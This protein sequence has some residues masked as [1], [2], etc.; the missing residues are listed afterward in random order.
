M[1]YSTYFGG[2]SFVGAPDANVGGGIAVDPNNSPNMY[3][4]GTTNMLPGTSTVAGFP[5][6]NAQ[7]TCLN[8]ASVTTSPCSSTMPPDTDTDAFVAKINPNQ[9]GNSSLVYSTY[10][11]AEGNDNGNAIAVD[12]SANA[13]V[14]GSTYS[15][16]WVCYGCPAGFQS[17]NGGGED[18]FIVKIGN[19]TSGSEY[20]LTY[21]TYLGGSGND[22]GQ[23]IQ[24]DSNQAVHVVGTTFSSTGFPIVNPIQTSYGGGG[25]AF[26][27]LIS[28]T[29]QTPPPSG[30]YV[31]YLGGSGLDQ[32]SGV[33]VDP[34]YGATYVAGATQSTN[35]PI[36]SNAFQK[37]LNT[38]DGPQNAFVSVIGANSSVQAYPAGASPAPNPVPAG[39]Q[40][41][42]TFYITN[43]G[44][45]PASQVTFNALYLPTSGLQSS[46]TAIVESGGSC[47]G[48]V[49]STIQCTIGYLNVNAVATVEVDMIPSA[50]VAPTNQV[51]N[52][53]GDASANGGPVGTIIA[54][55]TAHVVD[56][57]V[58]ATPTSQIIDAGVPAYI[59]VTFC[60]TPQS[61]PYGYSAT[62]TPSQTT[63]P[64][65]VTSPAPTFN[66]TTVTLSGGGC[67]TTTLTIPTVAR[68]ANTGSLFHRGSFYAAWLPIGG[69]SLVGL[70]LGASRK[71]RRWLIGA[72]LGLIAGII[73][74]HPGCGSS[75]SSIAS[76]TGTQAK[77]Y[78]V[79]IKGSAGAGAEHTAEVQ[80]TVN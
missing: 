72:V 4:T 65:M 30:D 79:T 25:D 80:V 41:A 66:P 56:F 31:T 12:S 2:G 55:P 8:Q 45:D 57:S 28:T 62:I 22:S 40:V 7:Q 39:N 74:L 54:Q 23:D 69:L 27:A 63:S 76:S 36:T 35:F 59:Q 29:D 71:R 44:P 37:T 32:G 67:G 24:V 70:G 16:G 10:L 75:S 48:V 1:L 73:L 15:T 11:G 6:L 14:I 18:A 26:V 21:F 19:N 33:A 52:I 68:P 46:P 78:T 42:F 34:V 53:S 64:S 17:T 13:Y 5:L 50:P 20:P 3:F 77:A 58:T 38:T 47:G 49:V 43:N 51:I 60:P 9:L 61:M